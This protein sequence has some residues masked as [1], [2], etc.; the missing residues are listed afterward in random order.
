MAVV[1]RGTIADRPFGRTFWAIAARSFTGDLLVESGGKRYGAGW[2]DG[3]IVAGLSP[4]PSDAV[5]RLALTA[6]LVTSSQVADILRA[7]T[8][9]RDEVDVVAE[10]AR[11]SADQAER[12]RRRA[13]GQ[14]AMRLFALEQGDIVVDDVP[15]LPQ[16]PELAIDARAVLYAGVKAHF[17]EARLAA[18]LAALGLAFR[19]RDAA[20]VHLPQYGFG[21]TERQALERLR[22]DP[23]TPEQLER[24]FPQV[25]AKVLRAML[26]AL[27]T[28]GAVELADPMP[29]AVGVSPAT[30]LAAAL[31][32]PAPEAP[33]RRS[34]P[35]PPQRPKTTFPPPV[36]TKPLEADAIRALI[37]ERLAR[38]DVGADHFAL[39]GVTQ[40]TPPE[41]V[42]A[43]Y[44]ELARQLHPDR[45]TAVGIGDETR[46]AQRLFAS[47]NG[48]FAVLSN[49]RRR[50]D[51]VETLR[52]GGEKEVRARN[53][54]AEEAAL[55]AMMAE[56]AFR[57]GE[58]AMRRGQFV[59]AIEEF[60]RAV[61][62]N[63][64]EGE[65]HALLGW[66]T[67][68]AAEDKAKVVGAAKKSLDKAISLAPKSAT[69]HLALGRIARGAG[70]DEEAIRHF[71]EALRLSPG[72]V[73]ATSELRVVEARRTAGKPDDKG[74]GGI[75]GR[76]KRS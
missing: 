16:R 4:L 51:Y 3:S 25:E 58:M 32:A 64:N 37:R 52:A 71:Q 9:G 18:E 68:C 29:H 15:T 19:L 41:Q 74:K 30:A 60:T 56:E 1:A 69:P 28:S 76:F 13:L 47:I 38:L 12:L 54:A 7:M 66:A 73:E 24:S 34:S 45:L 8:P 22:H 27:A 44:F 50:G 55:K 17:S 35:T 62:L 49:P 39:L 40:M 6:Q 2:R 59:T 21:D 11:L 43:T 36:A 67:W 14:R 65:H 23:M 42:R 63:P 70:H 48:A 72:H 75:F 20:V 31:D 26:Y 5:A 33:R 10:V 61:E 57:R 46:D 53:D